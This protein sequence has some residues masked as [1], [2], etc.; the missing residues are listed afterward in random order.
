MFALGNSLRYHLYRGNCDMRKSFNGLC[1]L[2]RN[3]LGRQP[4][5]DYADAGTG[6]KIVYQDPNRR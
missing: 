5:S 6:S 1:G 2:I 4:D 3:E